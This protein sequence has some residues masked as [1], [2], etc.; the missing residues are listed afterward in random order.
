PYDPV[1]LARV[2]PLTFA[3]GLYVA[4]AWWLL[5]RARGSWPLLLWS[6]AGVMALS[7]AGLWLRSDDALYELFVRTASGVTT[8][9]HFAGAEI[10]WSDPA[11]VNWPQTVEPFVGRSGHIVLSGPALPLL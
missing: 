10:D 1:P 7:V 8:G 6:V 3:L 5:R 11:W 9:Q 4:G 2:V